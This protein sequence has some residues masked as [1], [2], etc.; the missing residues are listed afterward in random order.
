MITDGL[1]LLSGKILTIDIKIDLEKLFNQIKLAFNENVLNDKLNGNDSKVPIFVLGMP[2][3]GTSMIEQILASHSEVYGAG[4]LNEIK[5]IAGT[6]LA[7]LKNNSVENIG[8][9]SSDE[10][11]KFGGEYVE[12]INNILKEGLFQ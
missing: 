2:R 11:I 1:I 12:R 4:E 8:D 10:R 6:N 5:D 3:S 7:F 9:L